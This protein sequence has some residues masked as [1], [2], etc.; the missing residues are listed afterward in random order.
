MRQSADTKDV[1]TEAEESTALEDVI[2]QR[3]V[4][5]QPTEKT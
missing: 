2:K 4:K 1:N 3:L 5:T